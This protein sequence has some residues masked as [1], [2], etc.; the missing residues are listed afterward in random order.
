M[1]WTVVLMLGAGILVSSCAGSGT[2]PH[3]M[4]VEEHRKAAEN[5]EREARIQNDRAETEIDGATFVDLWA[6]AAG[7]QNHADEH[8]EAARVLESQA[9]P[10]A[11]VD[12]PRSHVETCPLE[13]YKVLD[14][15]S[16]PQG[17]KVLY[18]AN[19]GTA[20]EG[21]LLCHQAHMSLHSETR[22]ASCPLESD[23]E[24]S[25]VQDK[26]GTWV[27]LTSKQPEKAKALQSIYVKKKQTTPT[28][29]E[30]SEP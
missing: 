26:R 3:D 1:K 20:F 16:I 15:E 10:Q 18:T 14:V 13:A 23:V 21:H 11:C 19:S 29:P 9:N 17:V 22:E 25:V 28:T 27:V 30:T 8:R 24:V 4:S 7:Y 5:L 6:L 2:R 12:H